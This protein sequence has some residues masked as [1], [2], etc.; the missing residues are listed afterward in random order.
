CKG[1]EKEYVGIK[2][3]GMRKHWNM[4]N[5]LSNLFSC[6]ISYDTLSD[7]PLSE[8]SPTLFERSFA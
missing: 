3:N 5:R 1:A 4:C 8:C 6:L 7:G 2:Q